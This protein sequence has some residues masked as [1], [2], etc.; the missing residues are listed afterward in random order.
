MPLPDDV[1]PPNASGETPSAENASAEEKR[2]EPAA[3]AAGADEDGAPDLSGRVL[4]PDGSCIGV[5]GP[6]GVC[7]VCGKPAATQVEQ[8]PVRTSGAL[9]AASVDQ[10]A[11]PF[12]NQESPDLEHRR[13]CSDGAC[14]GVI[15]PDD[16]CKVCS[17]PYTGEPEL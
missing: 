9:A 12:E 7:K 17:K 4:C 13:L 8:P 6:Q 15:G 5:I 16:R 14:I 10:T 11:D 2:D 3:S 1:A